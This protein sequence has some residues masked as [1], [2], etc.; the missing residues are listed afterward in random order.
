MMFVTTLLQIKEFPIYTVT[1]KV[2]YLFPILILKKKIQLPIND[3]KN[4]Y[5]HLNVCNCQRDPF[6]FLTASVFLHKA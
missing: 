1:G 4:Q 3:F 5:T 2:K 6:L